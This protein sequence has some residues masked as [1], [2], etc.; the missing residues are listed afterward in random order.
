MYDAICCNVTSKSSKTYYIQYN[1]LAFKGAGMS[2]L[3]CWMIVYCL[4]DTWHKN[5]LSSGRPYT[6]SAV[7]SLL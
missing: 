6:D 4:K 5:V 2:C 1:F 7:F 3:H